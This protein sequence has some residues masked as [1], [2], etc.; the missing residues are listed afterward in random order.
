M[1]LV[2]LD[3]LAKPLWLYD[4]IS[5]QDLFGRSLR[6]LLIPGP[7]LYKIS[8][9]ISGPPGKTS[10]GGLFTRGLYEISS[11]DLFD[12]S[13]DLHER[14]LY[15][16]SRPLWKISIQD[17][18]TTSPDIF[19]PRGKTS[20]TMSLWEISLELSTRSH[21]QDLDARSLYKIWLLTSLDLPAKPPWEISLQELSTRSLS[22]ASTRDLYTR[23]PHIPAPPGNTS[24]RD[25][26]TG[27]K[28]SWQDLLKNLYTRRPDM[29]G[30]PGKASIEDPL[31]SIYT[32]FRPPC[33]RIH[34][35]GSFVKIHTALR[36]QRCEAPKT[37]RGLHGR[38]VAR[39]DQK[40]LHPERQRHFVIKMSTA[41]E[42]KPSDTHKLRRNCK[43]TR[44]INQTL[45][46]ASQ[47]EMRFFD[48]LRHK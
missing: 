37:L 47:Y 32:T 29:S 42:G 1:F 45:T 41:L 39:T 46:S 23:S 35:C 10:I 6:D 36:P 33:F 3:L 31:Q 27:Y 11:Q 25:L 14:S 7:S 34:I 15:R 19:E 2:S 17:L 28:N 4:K 21:L 48:V 5:W 12:R 38:R 26:S 8:P 43:E 13:Q 22:K 9:D 16:S 18:Y 24:A 20:M 40:K 30:P 44:K